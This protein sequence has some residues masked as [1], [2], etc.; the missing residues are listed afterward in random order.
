MLQ[1]LFVAGQRWLLR[2]LVIHEQ[3]MW[4]WLWPS[5]KKREKS[6]MTKKTVIF[7]AHLFHSLVSIYLLC[8]ELLSAAGYLP[9]VRQRRNEV[10]MTSR[11]HASLCLK[12]LSLLSGTEPWS[13][14][15]I[16]GFLNFNVAFIL[17]LL[18]LPLTCLMENLLQK[19]H[20]ECGMDMRAENRQ[21]Y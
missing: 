2:W 13:F 12:T 9:C 8:R 21:S 15:F 16:N 17:A 3:H 20:G 19:F 14:Y 1:N 5:G 4:C 10:A 18:V 11:S 7:C 6:F